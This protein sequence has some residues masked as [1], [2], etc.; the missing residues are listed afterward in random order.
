MK[1]TQQTR[2]SQT[3]LEAGEIATFQPRSQEPPTCSSQEDSSSDIGGADHPSSAVNE[4]CCDSQISNDFFAK[5]KPTDFCNTNRRRTLTADTSLCSFSSDFDVDVDLDFDL[6]D[7]QNTDDSKKTMS[8]KWT[9]LVLMVQRPIKRL[10]VAMAVHAARFPRLYLV[11]IFGISLSLAYAGYSTNFRIENREEALWA[12]TGS[13]PELHKEW[14]DSIFNGKEDDGRRRLGTL[15]LLGGFAKQQQYPSEWE[16]LLP[17]FRDDASVGDV[18]SGRQLQETRTSFL[19][20]LVHADGRNVI[21]KEG[22]E[23]NF[24]A[25]DRLKTVAGYNEFC[26]EYGTT[27]CPQEVEN[28]VC[29]L[30]GIP[31]EDDAPKVCR[32]AGVTSLWFHN[33]TIFEN[34]IATDYDFQ[35]KMAADGFLE[36]EDKFD[37]TNIIGNPEYNTVNGTKIMVSGTSYLTGIRLPKAGFAEYPRLMDDMLESLLQLQ[38]EWE[39]DNE[40]SFRLEVLNKGAYEDE[41]IRGIIHDLMLVPMVGVLMMGFTV[42]VFFKFDRIQSQ[43]VLGFGA[44]ACVIMSL[45][46]SYGIMFVIGYPFTSL[47]LALVFIVFGI[48]LD[49]AF[50]IYSAYVRTDANK[51]G[52]ERVRETMDKVAMSIFMTTAT[53]A[54]AF[55]LG[56]LSQIPAVRWLCVS[57]F[58]TKHNST[59]EATE[60]S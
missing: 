17:F 24:E 35:E 34:Q 5:D 14:V 52:A 6:D 48:G 46:S 18:E 42:L 43:C 12:P 2:S 41:F 11:F 7:D 44:V 19:A 3:D 36:E 38:E 16:T 22:A 23:R 58:G 26:A 20:F 13:L 29:F 4:E 49:D 40:I 60:N 39:A 25:L 32:T 45:L 57:N 50:I 28:I 37:I 1:A 10:L 59:M 33:Y 54:L 21:S 31:I 9:Q 51:S 15:D 55:A 53:T 8:Q 30:A 56:A 27:P 47:S